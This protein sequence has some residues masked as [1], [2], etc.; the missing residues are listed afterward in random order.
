M[1]AIAAVADGVNRGGMG[2]E[3]AQTTVISLLRDYYG[4]PQTWDTT[5][6]LDR[7]ISAQNSWLVGINQRRQPAMG[8]TTL[9]ALVLRGQSYTLAHVGDSRA[10]LLR[11]IGLEDRLV[12]DYVQG[13]LQV[14]DVFILLTDGV[15]GELSQ[16]R[17]AD[18][19]DGIPAQNASAALV[20]AALKAGSH[21]NV[22]ALVVRVLGLLDA[23]LQ[24]DNRAALALPIPL[25]LKVGE[26][27]DGL[28]VLA[29]VADN[30]VRVHES[31]PDGPA[32]RFL[33]AV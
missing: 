17:L 29:P 6:A 11:A 32:R 19:I 31:L 12:V 7:V 33:C 18:L 25:R 26:R 15:H 14:G 28:V 3:A 10:Y 8:M 1:G 2:K 22:T 16:S 13:D 23:T 27:M 9:N 4:T 24:D 20:E 21:D 30:L 5:V